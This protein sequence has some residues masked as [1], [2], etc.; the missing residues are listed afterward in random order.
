ME[1]SFEDLISSYIENKVGISEHFLSYELVN[2]LKQNLFDLNEKSLLL[3]AG[4]G[5]SERPQ[6]T[7]QL[8]GI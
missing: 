7:R 8:R 4:I 1:D 6:L 5:N 3:A 2:H